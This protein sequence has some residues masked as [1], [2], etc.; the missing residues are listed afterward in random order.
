MVA[1]I[2]GSE[3]RQLRLKRNE[4]LHVDFDAED[5]TP[6]VLLV[7]DAKHEETSNTAL[8]DYDH[9]VAV[10]SPGQ[11]GEVVKDVDN[12][13]GGTRSAERNDAL[14]VDFVADDAKPDDH[15]VVEAKHDVFL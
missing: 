9:T 3:L 1:S 14:H 4:A 13:R 5:A 15:L 12:V 6:D 8:S 7:V 2:N 10:T 11:H